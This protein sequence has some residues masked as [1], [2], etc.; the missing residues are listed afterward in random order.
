MATRSCPS[1]PTGGGQ[2]VD[3]HLGADSYLAVQADQPPCRCREAFCKEI[4][5]PA[6]ARARDQPATQA[7]PACSY[8]RSIS[9]NPEG[10][11]GRDEGAQE[12]HRDERRGAENHNAKTNSWRD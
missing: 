9:L 1:A 10:L 3:Q 4:D 2:S 6:V 12:H 7:E 5:D 8:Y 11:I